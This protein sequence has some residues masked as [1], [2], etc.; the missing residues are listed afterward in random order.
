MKVLLS[1]DIYAGP[2]CVNPSSEASTHHRCG[3]E[4]WYCGRL[5]PDVQVRN[6]EANSDKRIQDPTGYPLPPCIVMERG[7]SLDIWAERAKPD[8]SMAFTVCTSY[9]FPQFPTNPDSK[10]VTAL[11]VDFMVMYQVKRRHDCSPVF[12]PILKGTSSASNIARG[13]HSLVV[14]H[15]G[16]SAVCRCCI[17]SHCG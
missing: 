14:S 17:I 12:V 10:Q 13:S 11:P 6:V 4:I 7:E 2:T 8:R 5:S 16:K 1:G 9:A 15:T 3:A